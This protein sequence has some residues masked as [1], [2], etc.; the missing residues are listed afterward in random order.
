M[1][2]GLAFASGSAATMSV[3]QL[4][5]PGDHLICGDDVYGG[6]NRYFSQVVKTKMSVEVSFVDFT[7]SNAFEEALRPN[8]KV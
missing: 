7:K 6:T 5:G 3:L 8:T 2:K 1:Y 4:I